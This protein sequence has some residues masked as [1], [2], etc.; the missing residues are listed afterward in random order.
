VVRLE[1]NYLQHGHAMRMVF[2]YRR[3]DLL[4]PTPTDCLELAQQYGLWEDSGGGFGFTLLRANSSAFTAAN[5]WSVDNR[6]LASFIDDPFS[7]A[8][9]VPL[10]GSVEVPQALAPIVRWRVGPFGS[11]HGRTYVPCCAYSAEGNPSESMR[12]SGLFADS[13]AAQ[14][15]RL[16]PPGPPASR[17]GMVS[18][19][20]AFGSRG[21]LIGRVL[22][23]TA[24]SVPSTLMGTQ[25]RRVRPGRG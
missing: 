23:I 15:G 5:V 24:A 1:A 10:L 2:H 4:P 25:R 3:Y 22:D 13:L 9:S 17:L 18:L 16:I 6:S 8:G 7:R 19:V 11:L 20:S 21:R 14:F 12:V